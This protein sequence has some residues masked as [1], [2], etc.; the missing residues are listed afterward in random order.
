MCAVMG[1]NVATFPES[2]NECSQQDPI[3]AP[4]SS[5]H[6]PLHPPFSISRFFALS[7]PLHGVNH[8][9]TCEASPGLLYL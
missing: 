5:S 8:Y 6:V 7:L 2:P 3:Y 9:S 1:R 4:L